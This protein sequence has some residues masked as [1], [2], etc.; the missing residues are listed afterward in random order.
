MVALAFLLVQVIYSLSKQ[1]R[2]AGSLWVARLW[3]PPAVDLYLSSHTDVKLASFKTWV[4]ELDLFGQLVSSTTSLRT[5]C[6]LKKEYL[7]SPPY[8]HHIPAN[9]HTQGTNRPWCMP[10]PP[11]LAKAIG[12][13]LALTTSFVAPFTC[14]RHLH[15]LCTVNC[16]FRTKRNH[17]C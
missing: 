15:F 6:S 3:L 4:S 12:F 13:R 17:N 7:V 5:S 11:R 16:F 8:T 9:I 10:A 14:D 2:S 1:I